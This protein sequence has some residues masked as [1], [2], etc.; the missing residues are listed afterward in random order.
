MIFPH[1]GYG[2]EDKE[3]KCGQLCPADAAA[4]PGTVLPGPGCGSVRQVRA[5]GLALGGQANAF[6]RDQSAEDAIFEA[7]S[8]IIRELAAKESCVIVGRLGAFILKDRPNAFH[9]FLSAKDD[10]RLANLFPHG[11]ERE[12]RIDMIHREDD[13]RAAYC[14]HFTGRPWGVSRHYSMCLDT[15]VYGLEGSLELIEQALEKRRA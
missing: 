15:S 6:T 8:K 3:N 14:R 12:K 2:N 4:D 1:R 7:Q 9:L 10:F 11:G 13:L 5:G